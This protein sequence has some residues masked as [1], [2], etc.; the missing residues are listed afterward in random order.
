MRLE[1]ILCT[2]PFP[3]LVNTVPVINK[4]VCR[5]DYSV[6]FHGVKP[7]VGRDI[8]MHGAEGIM[9]LDIDSG[10]KSEEVAPEIKL[11]N[12]VQVVRPSEN[13]IISLADPRDVL[14]VGRQMYELQLSYSFTV[15]KTAESSL[16][17]SMLSDVLYESQVSNTVSCP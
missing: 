14:P 17:L 13:K 1:L 8:V 7:S 9:R 3:C 10:L 16:N 15:N 11:K 6:T 12:I 2:I 4:F 5:C